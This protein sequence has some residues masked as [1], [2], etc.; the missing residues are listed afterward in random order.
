MSHAHEEIAALFERES[1]GLRALAGR[2]LNPG[3]ADDLVQDGFLLLLRRGDRDLDRPGGWLTGSLRNLAFRA[4]RGRRRRA[5]REEAAAT[6]EE[7]PPEPDPGHAEILS[8]VVEA[9]RALDEPYREVVFRHFFQGRT[10]AA[11][12]R[13]LGCPE[14]T[15][16]TRLRRALSRLRDR[17]EGRDPEWR[18]SLALALGLP[19]DVAASTSLVKSMGF[20]LGG[21]TMW[22]ITFLVAALTG[23]WLWLGGPEPSDSVAGAPEGAAVAIEGPEPP[24]PRVTSE[25]AEEVTPA[26]ADA[27][28]PA[29]E[30]AAERPDLVVIEGLVVDSEGA[31]VSFAEVWDA[32]LAADR[33]EPFA[34][35]DAAG[36]FRFEVEE[37]PFQL[38]ARAE[39]HAPS[40]V[41]TLSEGRSPVELL[42]RLRG[43][44]ASLTGR[45]L[46]EFGDH[47]PG[48]AVQVGHAIPAGIYHEG[49]RQRS[50]PAGPIVLSGADGSFE[51]DQLAAER[52]GIAVRK[53]GFARW[54]RMVTP[55]AGEPTTVFVRLERGGTIVGTVSDERGRAVEGARIEVSCDEFLLS[56][57]YRVGEPAVST[58]SDASGAFRVESV[59]TGTAR[60]RITSGDGRAATVARP[61]VGGREERIDVT[62]SPPSFV[63]GTLVD[64]RG[65]AL[66]GWTV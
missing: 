60:L 37:T 56:G 65:E 40:F 39:G 21:L 23:G 58:K 53:D 46:D 26:M 12:A 18:A 54:D 24:D 10:L 34:T 14:A 31:A 47:V 5:V 44:A 51:V 20:V 16:R 61:I 28:G 9:A 17:L 42:F 4:R 33:G 64:E 59:T 8:A 15:V 11:I 63:R 43:P 30:E 52:T 36:R 2:L 38:C 50:L 19:C 66:Q 35:A 62:L 41:E 45:V 1:R 29:D 7:A 27:A 55:V 49:G 3:D 25:R 13:D 22:K 57:V 48:A 6:S 32:R